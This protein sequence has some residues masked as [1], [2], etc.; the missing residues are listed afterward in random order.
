MRG[1]ISNLGFKVNVGRGHLGDLE[2]AYSQRDSTQDK[3][4]VVDQDPGQDCMP[5]TP[6]TGDIK[7]ISLRKSSKNCSVGATCDIIDI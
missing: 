7:G 5:D 4:T 1:F 3:Q 2:D 6:I